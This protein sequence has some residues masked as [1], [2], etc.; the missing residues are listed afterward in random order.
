MQV[1]PRFAHSKY[2]FSN[3]CKRGRRKRKLTY[4]S[5]R[6]NTGDWNKGNDKWA[7]A[8]WPKYITRLRTTNVIG[9]HSQWFNVNYIIMIVYFLLVGLPLSIIW[10]LRYLERSRALHDDLPSLPR[11]FLFGNIP[12]LG[13]YLKSDRH[14]GISSQALNLRSCM[15][16]LLWS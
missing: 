9:R 11:S 10:L 5:V 15:N 6:H 3:S 13:R 12:Q 7:W 4:A 8:Q 14:P 16:S 1:G 2:L